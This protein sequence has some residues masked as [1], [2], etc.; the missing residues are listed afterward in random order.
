VYRAVDALGFAGGMTLGIVQSGFELV[1]KREL[2]GGFGVA[3]CESNRALLGDN[4]RTEVGPAQDWT[5]VTA[6]LLFGNPPC[7]GFSPMTDNKHRGIDSKINQCMWEFIAYGAKVRPQIIAM[8]S[9][10]QAYTIG[11]PLMQTLRYRLEQRTGLR[12]DLYH[13]FQDAIELGG[14]AR[15]PRYFMVL[16]QL[17]FGVDYPTV[18]R[19]PLLRDVWSDLRDHPLTW[20][21]Q[22]Y[23][24]PATWWTAK[25][26]GR[27]TTFDGHMTH[28]GLPIRRALDLYEMVSSNGG[29]PAGWS[30]GRVAEHCYDTTG[31]LPSS[32]DHMIP[33]LLSKKPRFHMGF[34]SITRWDPNKYG[35]VIMG[36]ALD[37]VMHPWEARTITHREAAR[38]MGFPDDWRI[39]PLRGNAGLRATWGK[40]VSVQC[41]RWIGEQTIRALDGQPGSIVGEPIGD[42]E[43]LIQKGYEPSREL[44]NRQR[45]VTE[46]TCDDVL[47]SV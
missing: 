30:I 12:Y 7:S 42:R 23:R 46:L 17:P 13:V 22:P 5:P 20:E 1:G 29:W 11:R 28:I 34:A 38:V 44:A 27:N 35:R 14:A 4:W 37:M 41:G 43:W 36:S 18:T 10:R 25:A 32:W 40:G 39:L 26:R 15:R 16:S 33:K 24:R 45:T 6:E 3:N 31:R 21:Q 47:V 9:V 19:Y 2:P 8:E